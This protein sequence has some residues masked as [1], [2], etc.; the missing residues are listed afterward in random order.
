MAGLGWAGLGWAGLGWAGLGWAG[1][2]KIHPVHKKTL[3][4]SYVYN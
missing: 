4:F 3:I 1:L 2:G